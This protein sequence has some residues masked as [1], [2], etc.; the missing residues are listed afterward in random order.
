MS[1]K[2]P[3]ITESMDSNAM[4]IDYNSLF[5]VLIKIDQ[6][7]LMPLNSNKHFSHLDIRCK[8]KKMCY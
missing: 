7:I 4:R 6:E 8:H 5:A 1:L 3:K 2:L